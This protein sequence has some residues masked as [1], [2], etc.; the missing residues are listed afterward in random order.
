MLLF[1]W[2]VKYGNG[3]PQSLE[4][5]IVNG[6]NAS[7]PIPWQVCFLHYIDVCEFLCLDELHRFKPYLFYFKVSIRRNSEHICGGTILNENTVL[8][9]AHCFFGFDYRNELLTSGKDF[10]LQ[11]KFTILAGIINREDSASAQVRF[12]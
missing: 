10:A 7:E 9:A 3:M 4:V 2:S 6:A 11:N 12:R 1:I 8:S 5:Y